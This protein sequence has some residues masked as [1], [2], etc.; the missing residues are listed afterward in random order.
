MARFLALL[1]TSLGGC[2]ALID[3]CW[4]AAFEPRHGVEVTHLGRSEVRVT[5]DYEEW[6][7]DD[8]DDDIP[9]SYEGRHE[10][11]DVAP[12]E[13]V[14]SGYPHEALTV[15]VV[16]RSD[17]AVFFQDP[18]SNHDFSEEHDRVEMTVYP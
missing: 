16:G 1:L 7:D 14:E 12:G 4:E 3:V 2:D 6:V 8:E 18:F 9:G 11:I 13:Q 5:V 15:T 10:T 17:G